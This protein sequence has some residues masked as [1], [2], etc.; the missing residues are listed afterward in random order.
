M[1][2][3]AWT[4]HVRE[5]SAA[6]RQL[7]GEVRCTLQI[8][9]PLDNTDLAGLKSKWPDGLPPTL[10]EL[11]TAGSGRVFCR[12]VWTPPP[13]ELPCLRE[14]FPSQ[15]SI[16]GGVRF[17]PAREVFPGNSGADPSDEDMLAVLGRR[18]LD[19]WCRSALFLPIGNGDYLGLDT[20]DHPEDPP[21]VYLVHDGPESACISRSLSDFLRDW[22]ELSFIGPEFWLLDYWID[23]QAGR[24]DPAKHKTAELRRLLSPRSEP[25]EI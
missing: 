21:V 20:Q 19:L 16:Y 22:T 1:D 4:D 12:Y 3:R 13:A 7:P 18:G 17:D 25:N 24:L 9:P 14:I 10:R 15:R 23:H 2:Y 6:I 8:D 11:W 5:F